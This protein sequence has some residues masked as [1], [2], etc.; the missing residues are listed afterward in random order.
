MSQC[1]VRSKK[2]ME[3]PSLW[4][5]LKNGLFLMFQYRLPAVSVAQSN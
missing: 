2:E 5:P 4:L 3:I 1:P